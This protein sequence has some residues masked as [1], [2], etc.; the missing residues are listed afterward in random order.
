MKKKNDIRCMAAR[1]QLLKRQNWLFR[2]M[3]RLGCFRDKGFSWKRLGNGVVKPVHWNL[4]VRWWHPL[5]LLVHIMTIIIFCPLQS[6][7][8][9]FNMAVK[10]IYSACRSGLTIKCDM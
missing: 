7:I 5:T 4:I 6:V 1:A 9:G 10:D 8:Y 3:Y 2:I